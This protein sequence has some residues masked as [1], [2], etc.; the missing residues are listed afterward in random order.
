MKDNNTTET[1]KDTMEETPVEQ[2]NTTNPETNE[3]TEQQ[4]GEAQPDVRTLEDAEAEI[5]E[6]HLLHVLLQ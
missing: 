6:L 3:Q 1:P 2:T 4:E 5:A